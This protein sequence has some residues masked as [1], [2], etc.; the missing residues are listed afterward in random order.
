MALM[1]TALQKKIKRSDI[2]VKNWS[3][4]LGVQA[5]VNGATVPY[6]L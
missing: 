4:N 6:R 2:A 3:L 1:V 5:R